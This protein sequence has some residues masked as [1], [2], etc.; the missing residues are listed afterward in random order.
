MP[1]Q[2]LLAN[3]PVRPAYR[4]PAGPLPA[5][6][7]AVVI[8][9]GVVGA[10]VAYH[11]AKQGWRDV[12]LLERNAVGA[13][14]TW[15]AAGMVSQLRTSNSLTRINKYSAELYPTLAAETGHDCGWLG[16]GSLVVGSSPARMTQLRRTVAM[17]RVFGVEAHLISPAEAGERWPLVRTDD[18]LG[19]V[20][21]PQDGRVIP[22]ELAV[23]LARGAVLHGATVREGVGVTDVL[24][25][26]GRVVGVRTTAGDVEC[27]H[28]VLA[29]GMWSRD[30]GLTIGVDI[31]LFPVQHHY[32][33]TEPVPGGRRDFACLR[34]PEEMIYVRML[35]DG[36][37]LLGA[38]QQ[39][40]A[41][42]DVD[43]VPTDFAFG[44][45][46]PDWGR[47][48]QPL[49]G[50]K[51]RVPAL[52]RATF[53][54][55]VNGPESFTPDNNF[56]MGEPPGSPGLFVL[57]GFNS[58]G[59]AAAGGVGRWAA[60]WLD[61]G[62][63][64]AD[65]W[66]VD[67]RR[68]L[69]CHNRR[70]FLRTRVAEVLGLH[71]QM[72]WPNR[73]YETGRGLRRTPLHDRVAARGAVFGQVAGWERANWFAT[74]GVPS[75][76]EYSFARQNWATC[77]ADE[78]SACRQR[79]AIFDQSTFAKFRIRGRDA[80][81]VLSRAC[82]NAIDGPPG[83]VVYTG[84][85]NDRGT[86]ESDLTVIRRNADEFLVVSGTAQAVRDADWL[87]RGIPAAADVSLEDVTDATAVIGL[88]GPAA[89]AI[90]AAASDADLSHEAFPF[91]TARQIDIA[92]CRLLAVRITYVGELGWELHVPAADAAAVYDTLVAAGAAH[93]LRPAGHYAIAAMRLEKG[94]RAWGVDLSP[95]DTPLEAGLGFAIDWSKDF[96]GR[97]ALMAQREAGLRKRLV[98]FV[99]AEPGPTLWGN[100]PIY[101]DGALVGY[102]T[103][104][105]YG[106]TLGAAVALGYVRHPEGGL[107]T[108]EFIRAGGYEI[109][110][111][112]CRLP[113]R[114]SLAA[115]YDPDRKRILC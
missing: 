110:N 5:R 104:A 82:A 42:W 3:T 65:L 8:G 72:A 97:A 94:Y 64:T 2:T 113:A 37:V 23:A 6:A 14:T 40:S 34:D 10:S 53:A 54:K 43:P 57:A 62:E 48:E 115:P 100:E 91:A 24:R 38:F 69:P 18:L 51:H 99:L 79:A 74:A 111:D 56:I 84:L 9:G 30:F 31:P 103:S 44:L 17:A 60:E 95:D 33:L 27:A 107:V 1:A 55:F 114:V 87:R 19:A 52:E 21:V 108:P 4:F 15:H 105:A 86:F 47:Y 11:L 16:V 88:M 39:E 58:I 73:E 77:V 35:D 106:P 22:A 90:A 101:R 13:G 98:S 32:V 96:R 12:L 45:L 75:L 61:A 49:R 80:A 92:G 41:A 25:R 112:G 50:G 70:D 20:W 28:A 46:G 109:E 93:G 102:T 59:I 67:I 71:Y 81:A 78:V 36:A 26:G 68:F 29:G 83:R 63:P 89:R 85:L 66:S 7:R 76:V